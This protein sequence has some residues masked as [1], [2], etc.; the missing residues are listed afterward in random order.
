M[1]SARIEAEDAILRLESHPRHRLI[2]AEQRGNPRPL[3]VRYAEPAEM[4]VLYKIRLIVPIQECV[5]YAGP[6]HRDHNHRKHRGDTPDAH[7]GALVSHDITG[8]RK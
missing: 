2:H 5:V 1:I 3:D 6:E 7:A 8:R 4:A